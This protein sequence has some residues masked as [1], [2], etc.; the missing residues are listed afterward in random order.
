MPPLLPSVLHSLPG[1]L[2]YK[3]VARNYY[4]SDDVP[5]TLS[6]LK[7]MPVLFITVNCSCRVAV[8]SKR[9]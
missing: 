4:V 7:F 8:E 1:S 3:L 9:A 5:V 6:A 2:C